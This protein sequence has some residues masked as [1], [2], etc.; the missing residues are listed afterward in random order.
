MRE[1]DDFSKPVKKQLADR[2]RHACSNPECENPTMGPDSGEEKTINIGVAA[3]ITAAA[4][5]GK[6]YDPSLTP[7]QRKSISNGIWLCQSCSK[8]H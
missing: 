2:V 8:A 5:G 3:H 6:R 1:R 4:S 7:D